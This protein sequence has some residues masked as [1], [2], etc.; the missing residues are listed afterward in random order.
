MKM[1]KIIKIS[2]SV[3]SIGGILGISSNLI[4]CGHKD[5]TPPKDDKPN[6]KEFKSNATKAAVISIIR[7]VSSGVNGWDSNDFND[8]TWVTKPVATDNNKTVTAVI[9]S[10]SQ[11]D[12]ATFQVIYSN[13]WYKDDLWKCSVQP[14]SEQVAWNAFK[15]AALGVDSAPKLLAIARENNKLDALRWTYGDS[16]QTK[17]GLNDHAQWDTFGNLNANDS[18]KGMDGTLKVSEGNHSIIAVISKVETAGNYYADPIEAKI[19]FRLNPIYDVKNWKFNKIEQLQSY[20][21]VKAIFDDQVKS[22]ANWDQ[23]SQ[24]NWMTLGGTNGNDHSSSHTIQAILEA[25]GYTPYWYPPKF[26]KPPIITPSSTKIEMKIGFTFSNKNADSGRR[27][28]WKLSLHFDYVFANKIKEDKTGGGS[29][30]NYTWIGR[31]DKG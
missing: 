3:I 28:S 20:E 12:Q 7:G 11:D 4:S 25:D 19:D 26:E 31:V 1:L 17:W 5:S 13:Q 23:F 30:F 10:A 14:P 16:S 29:A 9:K 8:F 18:Y 6:W 21:K 27:Q 24:N 2:A 15:K 22:A